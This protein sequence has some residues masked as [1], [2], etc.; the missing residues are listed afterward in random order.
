MC[1][2]HTNKYCSQ[3]VKTCDSKI[4]SESKTEGDIPE[5]DMTGEVTENFIF[6]Q[7]NQRT[8]HEP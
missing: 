1:Y 7:R 6:I 3:N 8:D 5:R 2:A 4:R